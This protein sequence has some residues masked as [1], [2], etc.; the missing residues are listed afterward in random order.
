MQNTD[1]LAIQCWVCT[2]SSSRI[3]RSKIL[4]LKKEPLALPES[5]LYLLPVI[6]AYDLF[7]VFVCHRSINRPKS[8]NGQLNVQNGAQFT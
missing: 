2:D 1:E 4:T 3:G 6:Y 8:K 7:P 5:E